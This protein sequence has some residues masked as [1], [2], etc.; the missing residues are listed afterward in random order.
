MQF[1][2]LVVMRFVG[3]S[4]SVLRYLRSREASCSGRSGRVGRAAIVSWD[5]GITKC[6]VRGH[7]IT[8][9]S[10]VFQ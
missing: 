4:S 8:L 5:L 1:E 7:T 2:D 6:R 3:L 9:G 10:Q